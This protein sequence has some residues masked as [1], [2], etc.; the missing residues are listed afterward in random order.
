MKTAKMLLLAVCFAT[1]AYAQSP[2]QKNE[3]LTI[4]PADVLHVRVLEAPELEQTVRVSD[5]GDIPLILGGDVKVQGL[6]PGQAATA[7]EDRLKSGQFVLDPHVSVEVSEYATQNVTVLGEVRKPSEYPIGTP[8]N[9]LDVLAMAGGI[10]DMADRHIMIKHRGSD[11]DIEFFLTN[12]PKAAFDE[13]M[14]VHPGDTIFVPRVEVIYIL[15]DVQHPGGIAMTTNDAKLSLLQAVTLA[16]GPTHTASM[17][18]TKLIRRRPDGTYV[19]IDLPLHKIVN[20]KVA[21]VAMQ[22]ND[23]VYVPFSFVKNMGMNID[24]LLAA[25]AAA[26]VYKF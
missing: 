10:T 25:A 8:R 2:S 7:I 21:D 20:G 12:N 11:K 22:P 3:S 6:T 17:S 1:Y 13:G 19:K 9:I 18:H 4:G 23:I 14:E 16:G 5:S 15:G 24:A 26:S